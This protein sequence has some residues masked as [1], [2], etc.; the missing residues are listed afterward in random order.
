M[1]NK[2]YL[3]IL[4][5]VVFTVFSSCSNYLDVEPKNKIPGDAVLSD[6]NGVEAFIANL[7][8]QAPIEDLVYFP[9]A[10]FNARGNT[11][12]LS[13]AQYGM[14]AIHSEWPNW[15]QFGDNWWVN[16]FKFNRNLNILA[17]A[18]PDLDIADTEKQI[19]GGE[20]SFLRAY[21]YY[22]LVKRYGGVP[23]ILENQEYTDDFESLR[24]PRNTEKETWDLVMAECDKAIALLPE[25]R[26]TTDQT[27]R[28]AT[29]W[30]AYALK[31]R[32]ALHAASIA[33]YWNKAPL[34]GEA[35]TRNLV[36]LNASEAN[37]YYEIS[38]QASEALMNSGVFSLYQP[39][40]SNPQQAAA[41]YQEMFTDPNKAT[42]EVIF[43]KGYGQAGG[44]LAHDF[45]GWNNP[46]QTSEGFPYRGRTNPVLELVDK[47]ESYDNPGESSP[48]MTTENGDILNTDGYS[49]TANYRHFDSPTG[50]FE[51]RDARFF[52]SIIYPG[53]EW[54]GTTIVIQGGIIRPDGSLIDSRDSYTHNGVTYYT[55]GRNDRNQYSGF[56]GSA[57]MTRSGFLIRKFL[58]EGA[59]INTWLQST[60]DYMDMRYAEILLNY[61]EAVVESGY[62]QGGA[63]AKATDAINSLRKRA[64]H[65]VDIPLNIEN[66]MRERAVELAFEN[67]EYWDLIRR[68][69]FHQKF[70]NTVK[71]A[72][73]PMI[74]LRG[75]EPQYIFVRKPVPGANPVTFA[76]RDYYRGIP[77]ISGNGAIQNPQH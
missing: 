20:V 12:S 62:N 24:V 15:N 70:D 13:L 34:S 31:S 8:Y 18:I 2:R 59:R 71:T 9:R 57:D 65:T 43:M 55:Y 37:R 28:R 26:A 25:N 75:A 3:Y 64:G 35:V 73:V 60:T 23:I 7:Y 51:G 63:I 45:D 29:K 1:K 50:I 11:G 14:E 54:K 77:N 56:D 46:N 66:V 72:L 36:G 5:G 19:L 76:E 39:N 44:H 53:T 69:E 10:G 74:D 4:F 40:P 38:I 49:P 67:K 47:Y 58:D 17:E 21:N 22:A 33:K 30:A 68:R 42:N 32:A 48:I 61:A 27:K 52:A 41:N 16:G 6:P